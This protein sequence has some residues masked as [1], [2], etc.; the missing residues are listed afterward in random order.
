MD[1]G[2]TTSVDADINFAVGGSATQPDPGI[3]TDL[4]RVWS[5]SGDRAK[6]RLSC[7]NPVPQIALFSWDLGPRQGVRRLCSVDQK[8]VLVF[9]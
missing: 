4:E 8:Q 3:Q 7:F 6:K 2:E 1:D 9:A 5:E